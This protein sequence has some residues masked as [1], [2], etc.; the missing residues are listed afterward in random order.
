MYQSVL[1][2]EYAMARH[3][4]LL[5]A[6]ADRRASRLVRASRSSRHRAAVHPSVRRRWL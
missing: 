3:R 5:A 2:A 6:A 4:E 1:H